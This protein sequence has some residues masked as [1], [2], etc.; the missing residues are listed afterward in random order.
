MEFPIVPA[1]LFLVLMFI[2]TGFV[3]AGHASRLCM[4]HAPAILYLS[5]RKR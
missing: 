4:H 3:Y 2:G 1:F 5:R